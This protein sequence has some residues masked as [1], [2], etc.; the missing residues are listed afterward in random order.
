MHPPLYISLLF[1]LLILALLMAYLYGV[2][3]G[4]KKMG[5]STSQFIRRFA[6]MTLPLFGWFILSGG[7]S[8]AGFFTN[9]STIPPRFA[10]ALVVPMLCIIAFMSSST[11]RAIIAHLPAHWLVYAQ[12]FRIPM[13]LILWALFL[14]QVIPVQM[15]FE[16]FNYDV[17]TAIFALPIGYFCFTRSRLHKRWAIAWNVLGLGLVTT[18]V[19]VAILSAPTPFRVFHN[20][21]ANTFIAYL[22]Y[23]WLPGFVVPMAY[24]MHFAS[25]RQLLGN[26]QSHK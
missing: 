16:G 6:W 17:L 4:L 14:E 3:Y 18:I 23:I 19:T 20:A 5:L 2:Q 11:G 10:I 26:K 25:L 15:T 12:V 9:F 21:P 1:G 22:P 7:L 13:E 24:L 8:Y